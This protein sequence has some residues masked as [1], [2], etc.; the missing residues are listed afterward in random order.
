MGECH[1]P[2]FDLI[3]VHIGQMALDQGVGF[4]FC[5]DGSGF[6]LVFWNRS[7]DAKV[8][9]RGL[10]ENWN[11]TGHDDRVQDRHVAIA[12]HHHHVIGCHRVVPDHL[13][14]GTGAIGDKKAVI[15]IEDARRIALALANG[16]VV[17]EQLAQ[18]FHRIANIG[19]QHILA[20]ELVIHLPHWAFQKSHAARMPRAVPG[21]RAIFSIIEQRLKKRWLHAFEVGLGLTNDV[22]CDK[23]G[24]VL[25]HMDKAVQFAQDVIGHVA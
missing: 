25:K 13:V 18:F 16:T 3:T 14:A 22:P 4:D 5:L 12:I 19:A 6:K 15:S 24:R 20:V 17:V 9:A 11:G 1:H 2:G 7:D 21:V 8:I 10:Q 23:F